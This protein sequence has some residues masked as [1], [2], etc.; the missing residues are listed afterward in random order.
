VDISKV[1]TDDKNQVGIVV[2]CYNHDKTH[3]VLVVRL[4]GDTRNH[5]FLFIPDTPAI[6]FGDTIHLNPAEGNYSVCRG[7]SKLTYKIIPQ[8]FPG[9][10]LMEVVQEY[11][12]L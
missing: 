10:L 3:Q 4:K 2:E 7:N 11:L 5:H 8:V 9:T 1:K 12:N 6:D